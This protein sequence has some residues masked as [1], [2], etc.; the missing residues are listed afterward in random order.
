MFPADL[1]EWDF[2]ETRPGT[3]DD[4]G[5]VLEED[6]GVGGGDDDFGVGGDDEAGEFLADAEVPDEGELHETFAGAA[7]GV[8][9]AEVP[10]GSWGGVSGY[11]GGCL[12][13]RDL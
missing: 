2:V 5:A 9:V 10:G 8:A 6:G 7:F 3:F 11:G 1:G 13:G 12:G 4:R